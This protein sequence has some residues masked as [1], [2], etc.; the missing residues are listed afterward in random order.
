M[1]TCQFH[2][3]STETARW[4]FR[5]RHLAGVVCIVLFVAG[6][7][8]DAAAADANVAVVGAGIVGTQ[9]R[10]YNI[11]LTGEIT[12]STTPQFFAALND[13]RI[14]LQRKAAPTFPLLVYLNSLGGD[15]VEAMKIGRAIRK[16]NLQTDVTST[17]ECSSSCVLILAAGVERSG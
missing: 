4:P 2:R 1:D 8:R 15:V 6:A 12:R 16:A 11:V 17:Q 5:L 14:V 10:F 7:V 3:R 9:D 13:A